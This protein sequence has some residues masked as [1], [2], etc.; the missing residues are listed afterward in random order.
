VDAGVWMPPMMAR[1]PEADADALIRRPRT[2]RRN[3]SRR[4]LLH[5]AMRL[6]AALAVPFAATLLAAAPARADVEVRGA[7]WGHGVGLSQYGAYGYALLDGRD[8]A[9]ILGHYYPGTGLERRA[10]GRI[11]VLLHSARRP[12]LC[13]ATALRA[14][15]GRRVRLSGAHAYR[16]TALGASRLTVRDL[17][18]GRRRARVSAPVTVTGGASWCLRGGRAYRGSAR[19]VRSGR[20][21]LVVNHVPLERYL[22]GVVPSEMPASWPAEALEAQADVAR[23]YALRAL[24]AGAAFDVYADTRS[25][26]Y[27]GIASE[28]PASSAA[29]R[30]T[31]GEVVTYGGEVAETFFFSTSGG[32]TAGNDEVWGGP[33]I[34]YLRPV[35]D[36]HDDLSPYHRWT[37]TFTG[38]ELRK[39]LADVSPGR[40]EGLRVADRTPSGR[41]AT[42]EVTGRGGSAIVSASRIQALLGLRS[43]WFSFRDMK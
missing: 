13:G 28:S 15:G 27:G 26:V 41:A 37:V 17:T 11:D 3:H 12:A 35:E 29:V 39:R 16:F 34:P 21:I 7:G 2:H 22:L 33:P 38:R 25:Q 10:D 5:S 30:A 42:V 14:A 6:L 31:R 24:R 23:S 40:F 8:H 20:R 32:E 4:R 1:A 19:L 18:S 9:W 43:T 36:P